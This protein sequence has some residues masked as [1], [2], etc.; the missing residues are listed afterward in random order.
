MP[1]PAHERAQAVAAAQRDVTERGIAVRSLEPV[2]V[3]DVEDWWVVHF[4]RD[5]PPGQRSI[6]GTVMFEVDKTTGAVT[7]IMGM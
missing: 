5:E 2:M 7:L 6:P 3:I 4:K 1:M